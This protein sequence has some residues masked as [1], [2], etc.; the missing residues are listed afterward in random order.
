MP[1]HRSN[2]SKAQS[3]VGIN[4]YHDAHSKKIGAAYCVERRKT[5]KSLRVPRFSASSGLY[6]CNSSQNPKCPSGELVTLWRAF[7]FGAA[8]T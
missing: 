7:L 8:A 4:P 2:S 5:L 1:P 3:S 6:A